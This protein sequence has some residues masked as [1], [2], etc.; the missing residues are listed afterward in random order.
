MRRERPLRSALDRYGAALVV[1]AA[2]VFLLVRLA[3][4]VRG[5]PLFEDE[6]IV[7]QIAV[8]GVVSVLRTVIWDRGGAPLHF[9]L[10]H[11]VLSVDGS[12][13]ALRW[14]SVIAAIATVPVTFDLGRRVGGQQIGALAAVVCASSG[15]LSVVG[16]FGRMYA[17]YALV[18]ALACDLFV[19][20]A[21]RPTQGSLALAAGAAWLLPAT[22]PYGGILLGMEAIVA[23][24][25]WRGRP[26]RIAV[27]A[28]LITASAAVFLIADVRLSERFDVGSHG[29]RAVATPSQALDQ[30]TAAVRGFSGGIALLALVFAL[31]AAVGLA[32]CARS[33]RG[34]GAL[35][36]LWLV[37]PPLLTLVAR[38]PSVPSVKSEP[39]H[40]VSDLAAWAVLVALGSRALSNRL[41]APGRLAALGAV[42]VLALV[43]PVK[44]R[45]IRTDVP[46]WASVGRPA[47]VAGPAAWV[48]AHSRA[49]GVLYPYSVVYLRTLG[50]AARSTSL[51]RAEASPMLAALRRAHYPV[52]GVAL[53]VPIDG[54]TIDASLLRSRLG[55][56]VEAGIFTDWLVLE[57]PQPLASPAAVIC[58]L[59]SALAAVEVAVS[60]S[61]SARHELGLFLGVDQKAL[62]A[63]GVDC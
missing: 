13:A 5:K 9:V 18:G 44:A 47:A 28:I 52:A 3:P 58:R 4:D 45:D 22:H 33:Q 6:A 10:A 7:G 63:T 37:V 16:S 26:P 21:E 11:V 48:N 2:S 53:A 27:P 56:A 46:F 39:R 61:T 40:L 12:A 29:H 32:W 20:A 54:S 25:A 34:F 57:A 49:G 51:P 14:L 41:P 50:R 42:G 35:A 30:L 60:P 17:V 43:S 23:L 36:V 31:L 38:S 1:A 24:V 62:R 19:R 8:H 15:L 59:R 55:T